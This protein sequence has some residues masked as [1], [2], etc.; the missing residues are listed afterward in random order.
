MGEE[1]SFLAITIIFYKQ[2]DTYRI[3]LSLEHNKE[4]IFAVL[5]RY[6]DKILIKYNIINNKN[7]VNN[8][9][10]SEFLIVYFTYDKKFHYSKSLDKTDFDIYI[11]IYSNKLE[12]FKIK[13][14]NFEHDYLNKFEFLD[15]IL[16]NDT[17]LLNNKYM[18]NL[19][20]Q[21]DKLK[22]KYGHLLN[23]KNFDLL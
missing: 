10:N 4:T 23:A 17:S 8:N 6:F 18:L 2:V 1:I 7:L 11:K 16:S 14:N 9:I 15:N 20:L 5:L 22:D 13:V 3:V 21:N 19:I 12:D